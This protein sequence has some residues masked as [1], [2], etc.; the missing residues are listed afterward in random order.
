MNKQDNLRAL[1]HAYFQGEASSEQEKELFALICSDKESRI[2]FRE[3]E[4][5]WKDS[6]ITNP[7]RREMLERIFESMESRSSRKR[8]S[9]FTFAL[10][11]I[12]IILAAGFG[13]TLT[14]IFRNPA[15]EMT[16]VATSCKANA[17]ELSL[18]DGSKVLLCN[19]SRF[20]CSNSFSPSNRTIDFSGTGYFDIATDAEHPFRI[21]MEGCTV[22][23]TGTRF[24]IDS[25]KDFV[26][27][28]LIDGIIDFKSGDISHRVLPGESFTFNRKDSSCSTRHI[29][30]DSYLALMEG[31]IEYFNVTLSEL[32]SHLE[33]LYGK[34]IILDRKLASNDVTVSMHLSNRETFDDVMAGLKIMTPM[35]IR[36]EGDKVWLTSTMN[37]QQ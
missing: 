36:Q 19:D 15:Q 17:S 7:E 5:N 22:S 27:A 16:F 35:R 33:G 28:T 30:K 9:G 31:R 14:S 21:N 2:L 10:A 18:C 3:E 23:V 6:V 13:I 32:A 37:N 11:G 34:Q 20:S 24:S 1:S 26:R 29:D 4:Q 12:C 8:I 25:E